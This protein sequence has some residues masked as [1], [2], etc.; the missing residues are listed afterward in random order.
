MKK[1]LA[2][3]K[4]TRR[5]GKI[6]VTGE[7]TKRNLKTLQI[8]W[9][10]FINKHSTDK[11]TLDLVIWKPASLQLIPYTYKKK[12]IVEFDIYQHLIYRNV[13]FKG[14]LNRRKGPVSTWSVD[15]T[16]DGQAWPLIFTSRIFMLFLIS[17]EK[18]KSPT[19]REVKSSESN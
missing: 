16:I 3:I 8:P 19:Y 12:K 13:V 9:N 11:I 2:L 15:L 10:E 17:F 14:K 6:C 5:L 7:A 1:E 18:M 4:L